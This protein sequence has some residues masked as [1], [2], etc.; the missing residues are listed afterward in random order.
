MT[1]KARTVLFTICVLLFLLATPSIVLYSQGY[2]FDFD[3]KSVVQTGAFYFKVLPKSAEVYLNGKLKDKT[4][5]LTGSILIENLLP[6][7]YAV[8]IKKAGFHPWRKSLEIKEKQVTEAKNIIL[9][10][11]NPNFTIVSQNQKEINDIISEFAVSATSSDKKKV[12]ECNNYEIW[13]LFLENQYDQPQKQA[14]DKMFLTRFSEKIGKVFWLTSYYLIFDVGD[15][16]KIAEIDDRDKINIIDLAEFKNPE[17]FWNQD[18]KKLYVLS[19]GEL[20]LLEN[21]LP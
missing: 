19:E 14:G 4:S 13:I 8:E 3:K 10:P 1:R 18:T 6:Q 11:K 17:I 20:Y 7:T 16:I 12:I 5:T 15:K 21:L 9:F 2:R